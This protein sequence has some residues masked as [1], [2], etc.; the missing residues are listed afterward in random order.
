[1][2][3]EFVGND[4]RI[5]IL[6]D[7]KLINKEDMF[8]NDSFKD[9]K[10]EDPDKIKKLEEASLNYMGKNDFKNLKTE[11]LDIKWKFLTKKLAYPFEHFNCLDDYQK[12]VDNSTKSDF[13][14]KLRNDYLSD[15]EIER[16]E[17]NIKLFNIKNGEE[18]THLYLKSDVFLLASFFQ[19]FIKMSVKESGL[20]PLYCVISPGYAWQCGLEN[21]GI[22]LRTLQDKDLILTLEKNI[23]GGISFVMCDRYVKS[24]ENKKV[25]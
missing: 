5:N 2:G 14:S 22:N 25:I 1:M 3:D 18:L 13:F 8:Y 24:D 10:K 15:E 16:T 19:K 12:P 17:K 9:I 6:N 7:I 20:N 21:T 4:E 23:R 11:V